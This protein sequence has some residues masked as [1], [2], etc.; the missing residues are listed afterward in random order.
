VQLQGSGGAVGAGGAPAFTRQEITSA[1][2]HR[3]D[4][5]VLALPTMVKCVLP[6]VANSDGSWTYAVGVMCT[7]TVSIT[8]PWCTQSINGT[9]GDGTPNIV[10]GNWCCFPP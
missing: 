2:I 4:C 3:A 1:A 8:V 9:H 6:T 10:A 7:S 5:T